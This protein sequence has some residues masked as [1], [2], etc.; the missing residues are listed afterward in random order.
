[1]VGQ[2]VTPRDAAR[3]GANARSVTQLERS[4]RALRVAVARR[5]QAGRCRT[6]TPPTRSQAAEEAAR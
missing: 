6:R 4:A 2:D 5:S 1:M 3:R